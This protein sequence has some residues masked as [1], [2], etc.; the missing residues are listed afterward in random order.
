MAT[1]GA[2]L[3]TVAAA[4]P[5]HDEIQLRLAHGAFNAINFNAGSKRWADAEEW[6][7][8]LLTARASHPEMAELIPLVSLSDVVIQVRT[9]ECPAEIQI[10]WIRIIRDEFRKFKPDDSE[11]LVPLAIGFLQYSHDRSVID[12]LARLA[13]IWPSFPIHQDGHIGQLA[14]VVSELHEIEESIADELRR[15]YE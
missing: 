5:K 4:Y 7:G 3:V 8:K 2:R 15:L 11:H 10:E 13:R 14:L 6:H 9:I 1:W 12:L